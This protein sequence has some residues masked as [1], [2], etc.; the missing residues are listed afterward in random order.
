MHTDDLLGAAKPVVD[1][2]GADLGGADTGVVLSDADARVVARSAANAWQRAQLDALGLAPGHSWRVADVG[3]NAI[4]LVSEQQSPVQVTG[5]EHFMDALAG[6]TMAS[7]PVSDPR[8]GQLLG[9]VSLVCRVA[10]ANSLL[11]PVARRTAREIEH[12]LLDGTSSRER[13]L[14]EH[15]LRARRHARGAVV[16]VGE[17][18]MLI[19]AAAARL[20]GSGDRSL[21][22]DVAERAIEGGAASTPAFRAPNDL[23]L[24]ATVEAVHD[25]EDVAGALMRLTKLGDEPDREAEPGRRNAASVRPTFGW[26]SLSETERYL[27]D[28]VAEGLTNKQAAARLFLSRH[29]IDSHLRHIYCKLG[30]NSRVELTRLVTT[31]A[32][33][34]AAA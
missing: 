30:I 10:S 18:T 6:M 13:V 31:Y 34:P 15:F 5:T 33:A 28:L 4:G 27:A 9:A 12:R 32:D 8:T 22:W 24:V 25:G 7:A 14:Q 26:D 1:R 23:T 16:V 17:R 19:N 21:L 20:V 11:L 29:T 2:L 3:T